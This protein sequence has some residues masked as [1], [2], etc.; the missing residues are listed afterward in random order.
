MV[1]V[2]CI[3]F[4]MI[5]SFFVILNSRGRFII[6]I[7]EVVSAVL[8]IFWRVREIYWRMIFCHLSSFLTIIFE[9]VWG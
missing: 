9:V 3:D 5:E 2:V 6:I 8:V 4:L 7:F 1:L